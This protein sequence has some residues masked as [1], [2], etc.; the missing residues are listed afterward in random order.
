MTFYRANNRDTCE[1]RHKYKSNTLRGGV[2][3]H[4][5]KVL[6]GHGQNGG[7]CHQY[8]FNSTSV[9][10]ASCPIELWHPTTEAQTFIHMDVN[11]STK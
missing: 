1:K 2:Q 10:R 7:N 11:A 8:A 4:R 9:H 6:V 3:K 5:K